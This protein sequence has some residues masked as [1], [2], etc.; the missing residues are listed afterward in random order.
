[1]SRNPSIDTFR[2][3]TIIGM[4]FFTLT[5]KLSSNLPEILRHNSYESLH[6]GDFILPM[7]LFASGLSLAYYL[8]KKENEEKRVFRTDVIIRFSRLAIIGII[9][10][11][12]SANGFFK[13]DEVM[14]CAILFIVCIII[15][16]INWKILIFLICSINISYIALK[17]FYEISFFH[18]H[19]LGGYP[20]TL[21][22]LPVMLIGFI[23]GKEM[24]SKGLWSKKNKIIIS[25]ILFFFLISWFF[26]PIKKLEATPSFMMLSILF[27]FSIFVF[28]DLICNNFHRFKEIEYLGKKSIR[29]WMTMYII[30]IIPAHFYI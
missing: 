2:G 12:F 4:V 28:V 23:I 21:Y 18:K 27:S 20:A 6:I 11:P 17:E 1:M 8:Q 29:Y 9:L 19:Y 25:I 13:M 24:I 7:F 16:K 26:I 3:T 30:F 14:L 5:L 15:S 10:S 22:Y